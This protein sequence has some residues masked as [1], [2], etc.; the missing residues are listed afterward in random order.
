M[1][2]TKV[3]LYYAEWCGHCNKFK[4][5]WEK[6]KKNALDGGIK[7]NEYEAEKDK[8]KVEEANVSGFPTIIIT[9]NGK[10]EDYNGPRT[11]EALMEYVKGDKPKPAEGGKYNQCGAGRKHKKSLNPN[12]ETY[13]KVKYFKYKAKY[14]ESKAEN[15]E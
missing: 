14:M 4:P 11:A 7:T 2:N 3:E 10:K 1:S 5:E 9:I 15:D 8:T 6:F 13:Y 12:H